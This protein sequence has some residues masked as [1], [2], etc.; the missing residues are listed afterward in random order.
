MSFTPFRDGDTFSTF[1]GHIERLT[2]EI[3]GL[4]N[5]YVLRTSPTELEQYFLDKALIEPLTL[6]TDDYHIEDQ[7]SIQVDARR[8]PNRMF[9]PGDTPYHIPGTQLTI[10]IPFEGDQLLWKIRASTWSLSGYPEINLRGNDV[11]LTHQFADDAANPTKLKEEIDRQVASLKNAVEN[12]RRDV[13]Q[14]NASAP[15]TIKAELERKRQ[16]A[17]AA[18]GAVSAIGIPIKRKDQPATYV[19]PVSRRK[20]PIHRPVPSKESFKPEPELKDEEYQHI[21]SVIRSL[22]L[23]IERNPASFATLDEESIRDHILLQL[24][25]HYEGAATGETFNSNGKTDILIRVEDRNIFIAECKFWHGPKAFSE[26]I[27]QLLGY[28]TW[29]DCKCSLVIFNK[30]KNS[31]AVA[32]K[33]HEAT[34]GHKGHRKTLASDATGNG[35]YVFVKESDPG[36]DIIITTLLFDIPV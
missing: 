34:I 7:R 35:R 19:A 23:V 8:D 26:A 2:Q 20:L 36:R 28:L 14:H 17:Q 32:Q 21:L 11:L 5:S 30:Q 6:H 25:G 24:N 1:R 9:F 27:D 22:S 31:S 18:S 29:R 12:L 4:E 15:A 10:A 3:R 33:M 13:E 16:Q